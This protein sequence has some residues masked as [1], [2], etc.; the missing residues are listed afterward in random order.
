VRLFDVPPG[1]FRPAPK[2]TSAIVWMQPKPAEQ[3]TCRDEALFGRIVTAA[4]GQ[5][6]KTLRNTLREWVSE[7]DFASLG[8]DPQARGE[9]LKLEDYV[10]LTDYVAGKT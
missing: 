1:A 7:A 3:C 9:T 4:F 2:V 5:R 8:I 10:R 6:R